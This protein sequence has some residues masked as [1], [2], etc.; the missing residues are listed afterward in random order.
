MDCK[1]PIKSNTYLNEELDQWRSQ[2]FSMGGV[3]TGVWG[4]APSDGR[5]LQ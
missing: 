4:K 2:E 1:L 5:V 3:L